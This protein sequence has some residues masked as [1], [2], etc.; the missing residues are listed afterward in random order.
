MPRR[1]SNSIHT[2]PD[3]PA[4]RTPGRASSCVDDRDGKVYAYG[5][6]GERDP[7]SDFDLHP[8]NEYPA[9]IAYDGARFHVVDSYLDRMFVYPNRRRAPDA[10]PCFWEG[11]STTR[12]IAEN[13]PA[14]IDVGAPVTASGGDALHYILGGDDAASF[15]IVAETGQIRTREGV[16]YDYEDEEPV[17]RRGRRRV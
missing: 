15:D 3:R 11:N 1:I 14:G 6:A 13:T 5:T 12:E 8:S 17:S 9:G 4:S 16:V 2:I 7:M 10:Q